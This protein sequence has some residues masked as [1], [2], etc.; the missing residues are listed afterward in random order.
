MKIQEIRVMRGPNFWS[1][2]YHQLVV[3]RL[4]LEE[5]EYRPSNEIDGF[6]ERLEKLMPS[7]YNH[8][9]SE[10]HPG[11]FFERVRDGTWMG[12]IIEHM[13]LEMQTLAGME[14][15]F[16]RTRGTGQEG[17]YNVVIEYEWEEAGKYA[18]QAAFDLADG[19]VKGEPLE[20]LQQRLTNDIDALKRIEKEQAPGPSTSA[21][22]K[23]AKNR[24]IPVLEL[25]PNGLYQLGYG[26]NQKRIRASMDSLTSC[27]AVDIAGDKDETKYLLR[28]AGIPVPRGTTIQGE[29][30]LDQA[31]GEIGY[32]IVLKPLDGHQ[33]KGITVGIRTREEA[34][35]ALQLAQEHSDEVIVEQCIGG[36]DFRWLV[37]NYKFVAASRRR[38]AAITGDGHSSIRQLIDQVNKDPKRGKGHESMLTAIKID[39]ITEGILEEKG[40]T[41][42][43]VLPEGQVLHLKRTANLSTGGTASDVTDEMHPANVKLAER[44]ARVIGL[45]ICG[46]DVAAPRIDT[47]IQAN[48]GAVL[49]VNAAPGLRMHLAPAEGTARNVAAPI[50]DMLFPEDTTARI[51]IVA[52]TGTN[53]KT[54]VTRLIAHLVQTAGYRVGYTTTDGIYLGNELIERGDNTGPL[55]AQTVLKDSSVEF[56]VLECARGGLLRSGLGF[57]QCDVGVVTNVASDH[58]GMGGINT[59]EQ[60]AKAKAVVPECVKPDGF[61]ILNAE[62]DLVYA[63]RE[64]VSCNV[65]LFSLDSQHER[66]IGHREQGGLLATVEEGGLV[67]YDSGQRIILGTVAE[68]PATFDGTADYMVQNVLIAALA[69]YVRGIDATTIRQGLMSFL[70]SADTT[71]GRMNIFSFREFQVMVDYAHNPAALRALGGFLQRSPA[72]HK[73]GI[74]TGVGDR[75]EEDIIELG[76]TAARI[77]DEIIIRFDKDLRG[78]TP[79]EIT[80]LL[81]RG[82]EQEDGRKPVSVF[83][84]EEQALLHAMQNAQPGCFIVDCTEK[85]EYTLELM[86]Q[87]WKEDQRLRPAAQ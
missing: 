69:A 25:S 43:S 23:E 72:S 26:V 53:G 38:A 58:L 5:L 68:V 18:A 20:S 66:V 19:L 56:A 59:L 44:I 13:A 40:L 21:I 27:I 67:I 10:G 4:D 22:L 63:M 16:G 30:E 1:V 62:D 24:R 17:V 64:R 28:E 34:A 74:I 41:L 77:F 31:I 86:N 51:P 49:E 78:R 35:E 81:V 82:I 60:L 45:D 48:K 84:D 79:E 55:S 75:R 42:D 87:A 33:G 54:T 80:Q 83:P 11:G 50:L 12:H 61:A 46:I 76:Q 73:I 71:P 14:C 36:Y 8:Y 9:C 52:I 29:E 3:M 85:V 70:P 39:S 37:V 6:A 47:P 7:L 32:P 57:D 15:G 65:A 2:R